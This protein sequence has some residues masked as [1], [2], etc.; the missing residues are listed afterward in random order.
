MILPDTNILVA[1]FKGSDL[2]TTLV[3]RAIEE[4]QILLS[5]IPIAEFLVKA[6]S[7]EEAIIEQIIAMIGFIPLD[8][9]IM[10]QT[11]VFRRQA[12]RKTKRSHLLDCFIAATA[13]IHNATLVT[14]DRGDYPFRGLKVCQPEDL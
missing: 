12:L 9:V 6:S 14:F 3:D 10:N 7:E 4:K 11:V 8:Q 2:V 5:I 13:K 1:Y